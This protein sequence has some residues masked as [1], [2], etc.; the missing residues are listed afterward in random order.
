M[1]KKF[2]D[3]SRHIIWTQ[4]N[5]DKRRWHLQAPRKS[6]FIRVQFHPGEA[7]AKFLLMWIT[8]MLWLN[9]CQS[10]SAITPTPLLRASATPYPSPIALAPV[11]VRGTPTVVTTE[12]QTLNA[13]WHIAA[14]GSYTET[15]T[16]AAGPMLC[17]IQRGSAAFGQ[18]TSISNSDIIFNSW[19]DATA[20]ADNRLMHL[21][22][23]K[24]LTDL[25]IAVAAEWG[26]AVQLMV[27]AAYDSSLQDHDVN[28]PD[29]NRRYSLHF[30]GRAL[31][32]VPFPVDND[33]LARLCWLAHSVG[34]S[35]VHNESDHCHLSQYAPSLCGG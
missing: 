8:V 10:T 33:K 20:N 3:Y 24:P 17:H 23:V 13:G 18:L 15:E 34:W 27:T 14:S 30:E 2:W 12:P 1:A 31:D 28:Q 4:I 7:V 26:D 21:A 32:V 9:A 22:L 5:A 29:L 19:E 35:W 25:Q 6:A 11:V 16:A